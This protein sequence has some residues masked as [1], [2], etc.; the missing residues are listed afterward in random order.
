M[1]KEEYWE[2]LMQMHE[3]V[4]KHIKD[5]LLYPENLEI[6]REYVDKQLND[7]EGWDK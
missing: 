6:A 5:L 2:T 3:H 4:L 7:I 1:G